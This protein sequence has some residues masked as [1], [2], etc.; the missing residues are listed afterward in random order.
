[1]QCSFQ[2]CSRPLHN[3]ISHDLKEAFPE[4]SG[5]SPRNLKYMRKFAQ[6]WPEKPI[7]QQ[8]A[9]QIPWG[10]TMLILDKIKTP[11]ER[12]FYSLKTLENGWSRAVL[13]MQ[14]QSE[15]YERQGKLTNNFSVALPPD[16]SDL[17]AQIFKD[18]YIL[19]FL[20]TDHI[21]RESEL[22]RKLVT[23]IES[24]LLELG[25][26]FAFVGRQVHLE[27]G[28]DDFYLDLLFYHLKLRCYVVI[29]LKTGKFEPGHVSQ[30]N[31][32]LNLVDDLMKHP[33]D[34]P[35]IGLLLV[36]ERN[37]LV[38]EYA[39]A[40]YQK[41]IGIAEWERQLTQSLPKEL[42]SSKTGAKEE[43]M[44]NQL[45][46]VEDPANPT[47]V[48]IH[49][50]MLKEGWDVT[51][52]YTIVPLRAAN[53]RILIEQSIGRGLRLPYGKR[54]GVT[55]VDRLSIVAHDKFQEIVDEANRPDSQIRM[56]TVVLDPDEIEKKK[57][58]VVSQ[59]TLATQLGATPPHT[60]TSTEIAKTEAKPA[61]DTP[62]EQNIA[63]AA[64]QV[65]KKLENKPG[66]V[67][68]TSSLKN[69]EIQA[70]M[71]EEVAAQ[72][73]PS[74][75]EMEGVTKKPDIAAIVKKATELVVQQTIDIPRILVVP[76]GEVESGFNTFELDTT[77]FN[78]SPVSDVIW[79]QSLRTGLVVEI[80]LGKGGIEETRLEDYIVRS[81]I[82][83]D[84]ID[85][86][87]HAD[88]LYELANQTLQHLRGH[89][90]NEEAAK[91]MQAYQKDI[92][93]NIHAQM[94]EHY[95]EDENVEYEVV[96]SKGF[97]E[98]KS[99]AY[100]TTATQDPLDF[101]V[102]P[103]DKSNMSKYLFGG[104]K[105]CLYPVQKFDAEGERVLS[106]ILEREA[107]KWFKPA[108]GQFQIFYKSGA[109][110]PEYQPDF[111]AETANGIYMLEPKA[112]GNMSD[113]DVLAKK[114]AAEK[115]CKNAT[116]H[117][118]KHS[119]KPWHYKLIPHDT[120]A[121]NMS[122]DMLGT[123]S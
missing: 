109:D 79:S 71:V 17:A 22:E 51:N 40:G 112:K 72:F 90:S 18:P 12:A 36:K 30:L 4:M 121:E 8:S 50:N 25:Q 28:G 46:T 9:A 43:E 107:E 13:R 35:T 54:V 103:K 113:P 6:L 10:S 45:L 67:P 56:Q 100:T 57:K 110:H 86:E 78:Y 44:I 33:D 105:K 14:I 23:H 16:E 123:S 122:I 101:K 61:F 5:F 99:S 66:K 2:L 38:A 106:V 92:S 60:T 97:T 118:A 95:W 74:Q 24:F 82:D 111:V 117:T 48:V 19:D 32:Y 27:V 15:L 3:C 89:L 58:T 34:K 11:E 49:V 91:V 21:H 80:G 115:W 104:F 64:Y 69:K 37:R 7:V 94:Q 102:S 47:E 120:I 52:L 42:D 39:L 62:A 75:L 119:G 53:A 65:I 1:M 96:I 20:G 29:E 93:Q 68:S 83:F 108:K 85:Y 77:V 84:D 116:E 70:A 73:T 55:A 114:E 81:L 59:S 88:L 63:Q 41:P 26:G 87:Q 31:M 98:L 76:K